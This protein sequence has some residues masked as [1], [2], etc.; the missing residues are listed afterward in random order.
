MA[1][2]VNTQAAV[3]ATDIMRLFDDAFAATEN[4]RLLGGGAEPVYLPADKDSGCHRII[5]TQDYAAS[6]LHE[7]AHWCVAGRA[8]RQL[9][10][11][12]YWYAPDGRSLCQQQEF[13]RVEVRPQALEWLFA[14]AV[15][16]RFRVS[17]DNLAAGLGASHRFKE[18]IHAQVLDF[19]RNGV[20]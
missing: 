12:G 14:E 6:A 11:Y 3:M 4:T 5:F 16:L 13:E 15:G 20:N 9:E 10:D 2:V 7:I 17:A 8:R 19:C 18:A 1:K